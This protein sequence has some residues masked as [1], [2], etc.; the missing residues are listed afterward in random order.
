MA[1]GFVLVQGSVR[2]SRSLALA[3]ERFLAESV[4]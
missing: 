4:L 3:M 2:E 1:L